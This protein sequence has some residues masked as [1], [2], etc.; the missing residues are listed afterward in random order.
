M[1]VSVVMP[2]YNGARFIKQAIDS[3]LQQTYTNFELI[4][5]DDCSNDDS[6][7]IAKSYEKKDNRV[8]V[9][10]NKRNS[11]V[12]ITRNNGIKLCK[13]EYIALID[14]DDFWLLN[15]L[16]EQVE[17]AKKGIDIVYCSYSFCDENNNKIKKPFIVPERTSFKK[18]LVSNVISCSTCFIKSTL[19]KEHPFDPSYYHE[20]Y[21]LWLELLKLPIEAAGI[22]QVLSL[23]R[24]A[25]GSRSRDKRN[26][27]KQR[28]RIYREYC[29]MSRI[30]SFYY[31]IK[32]ALCAIIKYF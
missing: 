25:Q 30:T 27:A 4:I 20:D 19:L 24:L 9:I 18:M 5:V 11:G 23:Y 12:A 3:V 10:K 32:Y 17:I 21:V 28:W 15:K 26:A 2:N 7:E 22:R 29:Q 14:N 1:L 8:K 13:G 31:F 16:E 6:F